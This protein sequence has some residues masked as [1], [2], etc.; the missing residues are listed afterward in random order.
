MKPMWLD[1]LVRAMVSFRPQRLAFM[2]AVTGLVLA[3]VGVAGAE[4]FN[5]KY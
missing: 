4:D 5:Y 2:V 3:M 1:R